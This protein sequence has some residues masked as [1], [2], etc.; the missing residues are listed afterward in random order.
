M[1]ERAKPFGEHS[2]GIFFTHEAEIRSTWDS[3]SRPRGQWRRAQCG[4]VWRSPYLG[5]AHS[6]NRPKV[7]FTFTSLAPSP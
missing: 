7:R 3:N 4:E 1:P 6:G 5:P 2:E